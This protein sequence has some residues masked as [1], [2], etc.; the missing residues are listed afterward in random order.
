VRGYFTGVTGDLDECGLTA[1][2]RAK[3]IYINE[4]IMDEK[5]ELK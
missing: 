2:D 4:L 1:G 5:E 3:G